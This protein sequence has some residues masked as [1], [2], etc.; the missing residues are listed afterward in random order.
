MIP[1][2]AEYLRY[3]ESHGAKEGFTRGEPG[4]IALWQ[5]EEIE[6][7]NKDLQ[8][9]EVAPGFIGF[10]GD[11]GGE[12]LAFDKDGVV[13]KLPMIG[14]EPRY[15]RRIAANW[16]ELEKRIEREPR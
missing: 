14:M 8:V 2:P 1:L 16:S 7:A 9:E 12:M 13:Y 15:A 5:L 6:R 4:Y 11:G 3:L 10:G